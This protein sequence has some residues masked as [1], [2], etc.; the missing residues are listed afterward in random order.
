MNDE[1]E[2]FFKDVQYDHR[3]LYNDELLRD[4]N[5]ILYI[6][7]KWVDKFDLIYSFEKNAPFSTLLVMQNLF[8]ALGICYYFAIIYD[9]KQKTR[10]WFA[11]QTSL[12]HV[13]ILI[14]HI[15]IICFTGISQT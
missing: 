6:K 9:G 15:Y 1:N 4:G 13:A 11:I 12:R 10:L 3:K 14:C 5:L 2:R 7:R 8:I